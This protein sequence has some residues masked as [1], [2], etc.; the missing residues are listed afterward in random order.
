MINE[1]K[2]IFL[3]DFKSEDLDSLFDS[4]QTDDKINIKTQNSNYFTFYLKHNTRFH[5]LFLE[6]QIDLEISEGCI[7]SENYEIVETTN[8][9]YLKIES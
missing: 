1:V 8:E 4:I 2:V 7:G 3:E 6:K 5:F 9:K